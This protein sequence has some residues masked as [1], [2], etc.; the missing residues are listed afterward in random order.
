M[1]HKLL[2]V[3]I[4]IVVLGLVS[5]QALTSDAAPAEV[6]IQELLDFRADTQLSKQTQTPIL[7]LFSMEG[8]AYCH[9]VEEEHL[10]PM[11]RNAGYRE[12][13][14][15]R[16]VM[17][18]NLNFIVDIDGTSITNDEFANRYNASHTPTVIFLNHQGKTLTSQLQG[19]QNTEFYGHYLDNNL[20]QSISKIR[21]QLVTATL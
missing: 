10:K 11:L 18:D 14:I 6:E 13:V 7:V 2:F 3:Q 19:V 8:C 20:D 12:K 4:F 5:T 15:I 9:Y 1:L 16:R 21:Q 17:I